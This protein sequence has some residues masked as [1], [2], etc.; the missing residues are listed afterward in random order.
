MIDLHTHI[1]PGIDD[2]SQSPEMSLQ[3]LRMLAQ[4]GIDTVVATPHFLA[5]KDSPE[6]FLEQR[7]QAMAQLPVEEGLPRVLPG[8]EVAYFMGMSRCEELPLLRIGDSDLILIEMP[9]GGWTDRMVEEVCA[10][11]HQRGLMPVLAHV[12]R[13]DRKDQFPRYEAALEGQV[14]FQYNAAAFLK[15]FGGSA[16]SSLRRGGVHFLG[17]DCHNT[18][19]RAPNMGDALA[20]IR[21]RLGNEVLEEIKEFANSWLFPEE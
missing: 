18:G 10:L 3:M 6:A 5:Q 11:S 16:M 15:A 4:Q 1:L 2:G 7:K 9:F 8:A 13:Y 19:H 12:D 21:K 17:S 20:K 14:F